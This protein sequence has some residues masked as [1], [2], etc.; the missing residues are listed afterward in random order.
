[1]L[2]V[3][4]SK[5]E[6]SVNDG[7]LGL[8]P[9]DEVLPLIAAVIIIIAAVHGR[10]SRLLMDW[11]GQGI[12]NISVRRR[13]YSRRRRVDH[14]KAGSRRASII[15]IIIASTVH[16]NCLWLLIVAAIFIRKLLR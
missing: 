3:A 9:A 2:F 12:A 16:Q 1:M 13:R 14:S 4:R 5:Y 6:E 10:F 8:H 11:L 7:V 15:A